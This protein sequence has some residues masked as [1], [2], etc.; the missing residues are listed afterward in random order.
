MQP[1]RPLAHPRPLA[2][3]QIARELFPGAR[4][5]ISRDGSPSRPLRATEVALAV[6]HYQTA[7]LLHREI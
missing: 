1:S 6:P 3:G 7:P 5:L 4:A 2:P